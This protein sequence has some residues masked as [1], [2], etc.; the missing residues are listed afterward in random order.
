MNAVVL[1]AM[2]NTLKGYYNRLKVFKN[3]GYDLIKTRKFVLDKSGIKGGN[4]LEVGTGKGHTAIGLA[5]RGIR[6]R[7]WMLKNCGLKMTPLITLFRSILSI[8]RSTRKDA[9]KK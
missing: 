3:H 9:S 1:N 6:F 7:E 8:I 2:D 4:I 5:E